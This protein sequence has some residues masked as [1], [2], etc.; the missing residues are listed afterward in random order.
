[1]LSGARVELECGGIGYVAS[2]V[3]RYD[4]D[5]I[6]YLS[7][8]ARVTCVRIK[9]IAHFNVGRPRHASIATERIE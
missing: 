6:A 3:V 2:C 7:T 8:E 4:R 1:M 5:V 9:C